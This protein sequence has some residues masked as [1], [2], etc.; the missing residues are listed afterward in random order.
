L[1][2]VESRIHFALVCG[3]KSCPPIKCY[4]EE[5]VDKELT[6]ATEAFLEDDSNVSVNLKKK[7]VTIS[8]ILKWYSV[9]FGKTQKEILIWIFEHMTTVNIFLI[10]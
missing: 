9:D 3:A 6:I 7:K 5:G 8:M 4:S 2:E 10:F 1:P